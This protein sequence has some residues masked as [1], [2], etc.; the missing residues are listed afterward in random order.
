MKRVYFVML[1]TLL[2]SSLIF[3]QDSS[4]RIVKGKV[5]DKTTGKPVGLEI[6]FED[7]RG[8]KFK[9][10]SD[11]NTGEYEQLLN[12]NEKYTLTFISPEVLRDETE[13]VPS[14]PDASFEPQVQNFEVFLLNPGVVLADYNMFDKNST[15]IS[16]KGMEELEKLKKMM[17]INRALYLKIEIHSDDSSK[18]L[19]D[20]RL[21]KIKEQT[22]T[23]GRFNQK[24][25][26]IT[27]KKQSAD[28]SADFKIIIDKVEDSLK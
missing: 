17:R 12:S 9:I 23:W 16:K 27:S 7:P 18:N 1:F 4:T 14:P 26:Y 2:F 8:K 28:K 15:E 22:E 21:A 3:S 20:S 6:Q 5:I 13:F 10:K 24:V 25:E 19:N 11:S